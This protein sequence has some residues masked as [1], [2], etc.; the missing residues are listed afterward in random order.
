[1]TFLYHCLDNPNLL[2]NHGIASKAVFLFTM[3][4]PVS[5]LFMSI[6]FAVCF[7]KSLLRHT[8]C[9]DSLVNIA[10]N[11]TISDLNGDASEKDSLIALSRSPR[12]RKGDDLLLF[13][14][15][16]CFKQAANEFAF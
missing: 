5:L 7:H 3:T 1:M 2:R 15:S 6:V 12:V 4:D 14:L 16:F 13:S 9:Y 10:L 11:N 8:N